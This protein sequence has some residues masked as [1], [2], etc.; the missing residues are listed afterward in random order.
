MPLPPELRLPA[1][2]RLHPSDPAYPEVIAAHETAIDGGEDLY[3][4]PVTGLWA[5]TAEGLWNRG[6]CCDTGCRHCPYIPR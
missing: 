3:E 4:D 2:S 1:S 5:M 6:Y